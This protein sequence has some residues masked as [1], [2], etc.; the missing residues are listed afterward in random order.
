[1]ASARTFSETDITWS[2]TQTPLP[3]GGGVFAFTFCT[4]AERFQK[5]LSALYQ[6][7]VSLEW[8]FVG[9]HN[10]DIIAALGGDLPC[11]EEG[12]CPEPTPQDQTDT[13]TRVGGAAGAADC[14]EIEEDMPPLLITRVGNKPYLTEACCGA[15]TNF[16]PLTAALV[17]IDETGAAKVDDPNPKDYPVDKYEFTASDKN[18]PCFMSAATAVILQR[19]GTFYHDIAELFTVGFDVA[20][21]LGDELYDLGAALFGI[22]SGEVAP[23][24]YGMTAD[25]AAN[26]LTGSAVFTALREHWTYTGPISRSELKEFLSNAPDEVDGVYARHILTD[27]ANYANMEALNEALHVAIAH[28]ENNDGAV[29]EPPSDLR[30]VYEY[31]GENYYVWDETVNEQMSSTGQENGI[32]LF[33]TIPGDHSLMESVAIVGSTASNCEMGLQP[34]TDDEYSRTLIAASW[35]EAWI[36]RSTNANHQLIMKELLNPGIQELTQQGFVSGVAPST[37]L[38]WKRDGSGIVVTVTRF[39]AV[40]GPL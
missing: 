12:T 20:T 13:I 32:Q 16:Y 2:D 3:E 39:I 27:W 7:G 22:A 9:D 8:G 36:Y 18:L 24:W 31:G 38:V 21:L 4:T 37:P 25:Q 5:T 10:V 30:Y 15:E 35:P 26:V 6:G 19:G 33:P 29:P 17:S 40:A 1:M 23:D 28:C 14:E 11:V 34:S